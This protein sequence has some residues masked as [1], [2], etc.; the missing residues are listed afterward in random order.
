MRAR[1]PGR[2]RRLLG[3]TGL[4]LGVFLVWPGSALGATRERYEYDLQFDGVVDCGTF[5]DN[6]T[7]FYHVRETDLFDD[8]GNLLSI[9]YDAEHHSNDVNSVTGFAVHEHGHFHEVDD[10]IKGTYTITGAQEIANRKGS[11]VVI[12]DVGRIVYDSSF[13]LAFFAGNRN[14]TNYVQ[15]EQIYC[16]ALS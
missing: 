15:G 13:E 4:A 7:D 16:D 8:D 14:H 2:H 12:A 10:F 9:T 1:V 5:V 3:A 6:F 11:G